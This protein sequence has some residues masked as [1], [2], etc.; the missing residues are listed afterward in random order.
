LPVRLGAI[1]GSGDLDTNIEVR[2]G[3]VITVPERAL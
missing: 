1:L 2:P 3:D